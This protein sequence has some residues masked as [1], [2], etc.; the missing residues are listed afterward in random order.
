[1]C[2]LLISSNKVIIIE[3]ESPP[4]VWVYGH[5]N[6]RCVSG[7]WATSLRSQSRIPQTRVKWHNF[8][9]RVTLSHSDSITRP[10]WWLGLDLDP[11][12]VLWCVSVCVLLNVAPYS[13]PHS[14]SWVSPSSSDILN[15]N[16]LMSH[17]M[18]WLGNEGTSYTLLT[19]TLIS[20]GSSAGLA[21]K[22][23]HRHFI[24]LVYPAATN[25]GYIASVLYQGYFPIRVW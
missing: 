10:G 9:W 22:I 6:I 12:R 24:Q 1:M 21:N 20:S 17:K 18:Y 11:W 15:C 7:F 8:Q 23:T 3:I 4:H 2:R 19:T 25:Y 14:R 13:S 16:P 5:Q